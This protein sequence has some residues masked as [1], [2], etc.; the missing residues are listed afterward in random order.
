MDQLNTKDPKQ[1]KVVFCWG[2]IV[3][4]TVFNWKQELI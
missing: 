4:K 1:N 3:R 2:F